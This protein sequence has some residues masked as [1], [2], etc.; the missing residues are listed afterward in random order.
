MA[1]VYRVV[2][3][4]IESLISAQ[5]MCLKMSQNYLQFEKL[6]LNV[7]TESKQTDINSK[8]L[9]QFFTNKNTNKKTEIEI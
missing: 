7:N 1:A 2:S 8:P 5:Q 4:V 9:S 6:L 3:G